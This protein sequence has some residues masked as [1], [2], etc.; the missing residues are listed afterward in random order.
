M[1]QNQGKS[2]SILKTGMWLCGILALVCLVWGIVVWGQGAAVKDEKTLS[3]LGNLGSYLQGTVAS[4]WALAG[5]FL[6]VLA[7]LGSQQQLALQREQLV[8][9]DRQLND[10]LNTMKRH[11]FESSFFQLLSFHNEITAQLSCS[12]PPVNTLPSNSTVKGKDCFGVWYGE[13]AN[14]Y[15]QSKLTREQK[16]HVEFA[17]QHCEIFYDKNQA[18]L[19]HYFRTL[20]HVFKFIN[21]ADLKPEEKKQYASLVRAQLSTCELLLLFYSC[22]SPYGGKFKPLIEEFGLFKHLDKYLLMSTSHA[23]FFAPSAYR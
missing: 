3:Q 11:N 19:G 20:Y 14:T 18:F 23:E 4:L 6:L 9:Q 13:I 16:S 8:G 10:Q 5:V 21:G 12:A 17:Q 15:E 2:G 7:F 1:N 22:F